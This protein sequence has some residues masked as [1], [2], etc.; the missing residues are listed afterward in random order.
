MKRIIYIIAALTAAVGC[1]LSETGQ[2]QRPDREDIWKNPAFNAD[3]SSTDRKR[4][5]ITGL[6]YPDGYDWRADSEN[7]TVKCSLVVFTD[8]RPV[9]KVPVG[10]E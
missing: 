3:S 5:Y 7:G 8:G 10:H 9:M 1:S 6:D 2:S 4:C